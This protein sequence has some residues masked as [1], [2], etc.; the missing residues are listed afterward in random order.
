MGL[1]MTFDAYCR[2]KGDMDS[3]TFVKVFRDCK[4][5]DKHLTQN[6]CDLIFTKVKSKG[7]KRLTY[8]EFEKGVEMVA[9]K[10]HLPLQK[11][12]DVVSSSEG[13]VYTAT[14]ADAV[15]LHDDKSTYTGVHAHGGPSTVDRPNSK[16][17]SYGSVGSRG[18]GQ[19]SAITL[20]QICDRSTPDIR[21]I[22]KNF[23]K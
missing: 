2:G 18:S 11:I 23:H 7:A 16:F 12:I 10:K 20:D 8:E 3:R 4:L 19:H 17:T 21:G 15:R 5:L 1:S 6:D 13:P 9:E 22:N 14:I